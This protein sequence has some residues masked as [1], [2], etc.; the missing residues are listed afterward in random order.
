MMELL[1]LNRAKD[2]FA[3][4]QW[5]YR[6]KKPGADVVCTFC[7]RSVPNTETYAIRFHQH[8]ASTIAC[9]NCNHE[10]YE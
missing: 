9:L 1:A 3:R 4:A 8:A 2:I 10:T 5:K 6:T 7:K